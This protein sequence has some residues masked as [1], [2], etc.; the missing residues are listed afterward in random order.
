MKKKIIIAFTTFLTLALFAV[1]DNNV[2]SFDGNEPA[3]YLGA[4]KIQTYH[5]TQNNLSVFN[6]VVNG[7]SVKNFSTFPEAVAYASNYENSYVI[8]ALNGAVIWSNS[9]VLEDKVNLYVPFVSQRSLARGSQV[10]AL[11]MLLNHAGIDVD[12]ITLAHQLRKDPTQREIINGVVHSGNP[13]Y[14]FVGDI[15]NYENYG[16]RVFAPPIFELM[17]NYLPYESV[18]LTG[19]NFEDL[20]FLLNR[21][22]PILVI[23]NFNHNLLREHDFVTWQT[24]DGYIRTTY[25]LHAVVVTGYD[26]DYIYLR[27]SFGKQTHSARH[28]FI[29]AW[30]EM[31]RQAISYVNSEPLS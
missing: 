1:Q 4:E 31:G 6:I 22:F 16:F 7:D 24:S 3:S 10:A 21:G 12:I 2:Y 5:D 26:D 29:D 11:T 15:F 13:Y 23:T 27:D 14:G 20:L 18:N 9:T 8:S 25:W 19:A 28:Q 17:Q 30:E